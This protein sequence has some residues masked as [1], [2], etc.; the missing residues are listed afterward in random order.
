MR[1]ATGSVSSVHADNLLIPAG[2]AVS[3]GA[4]VGVLVTGTLVAVR[5]AVVLVGAL[6]GPGALEL[7]HP[8][9]AAAT[10]RASRI[11]RV[12]VLVLLVTFHGDWTA[13]R[14]PATMIRTAV[15]RLSPGDPRSFPG[16]DERR[17]PPR[18]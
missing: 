8:A 10:P 1:A 15:R 16:D 14:R 6:V 2:F 3:P 11:E 4:G 5:G 18:R 7:P 12:R 17:T 13:F 9:V